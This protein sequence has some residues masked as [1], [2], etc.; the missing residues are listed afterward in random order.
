MNVSE[1]EFDTFL[2]S[3]PFIRIENIGGLLKTKHSSCLQRG[4]DYEIKHA[5][6]LF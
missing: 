1:N 2:S 3:T 4:T 5:D 6:L